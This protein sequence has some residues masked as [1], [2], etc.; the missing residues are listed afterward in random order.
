M[1]F[2]AFPSFSASVLSLVPL[3][4]MFSWHFPRCL[5]GIVIL[6]S[7]ISL[8]LSFNVILADPKAKIF[9]VHE[10]RLLLS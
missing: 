3:I 2:L 10:F 8:S 7:C 6:R 1:S 4:Y 5:L 9:M